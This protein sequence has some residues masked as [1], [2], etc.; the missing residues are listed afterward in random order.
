[1]TTKTLPY[2]PL[3]ALSSKKGCTAKFG[4]GSTL[5]TRQHSGALRTKLAYV[6]WQG[7][8]VSELKV[9]PPTRKMSCLVFAQ[10]EYAEIPNRS[11]TN[12]HASAMLTLR[13]RTR[14]W[15][16]IVIPYAC[17]RVYKAAQKTPTAA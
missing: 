10:A 9:K 2:L 3:G 14:A 12:Q 1:M 4:S 17:V 6:L 13:V 8:D 5:T 16:E 7:L 15:R 11:A